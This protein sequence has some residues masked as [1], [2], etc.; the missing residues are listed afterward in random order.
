MVVKFGLPSIGVRVG[1]GY[2]YLDTTVMV[3]LERRARWRFVERRRKIPLFLRYPENQRRT[4]V[5]SVDLVV[6]SC[7]GGKG[8][9]VDLKLGEIWAV[10]LSPF[11]FVNGC[12]R[13]SI[14]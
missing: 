12:L 13:R 1:C 5:G 2:A 7:D 3:V 6:S 11:V 10:P 14:E 4:T 8:I 9:V